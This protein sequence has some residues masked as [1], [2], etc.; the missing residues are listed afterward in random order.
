MIFAAKHKFCTYYL[1]ESDWGGNDSVNSYKITHRK[2]ITS[3]KSNNHEKVDR[4]FREL[5]DTYAR[6][7]FYISL[8]ILHD[9]MAAEENVNDTFIA[10]FNSVTDL[11]CNKNIKYWLI[12]TAKNKAIDRLRKKDKNITLVDDKI[13]DINRGDSYT[14]EDQDIFLEIKKFLNE[15]EYNIIIQRFLYQL[16][17]SSISKNMKLKIGTTTSKYSRAIKKLKDIFDIRR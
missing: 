3:L 14:N 2:L 9:N 5:Y 12:T 10:V 6:I 15:D 17:F 1:T 4:A 8:E 11:D 13:L 7:V 16:S